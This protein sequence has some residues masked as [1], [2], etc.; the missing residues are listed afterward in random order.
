M[1]TAGPVP[2]GP[3]V[4]EKLPFVALKGGELPGAVPDGPVE[5][6]AVT[7]EPSEDKAIELL[8]AVPLV[9]D[10]GTVPVRGPLE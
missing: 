5:L 4:P 7:G 10:T 8:P 1:V 9:E 6:G 3:P 2:R